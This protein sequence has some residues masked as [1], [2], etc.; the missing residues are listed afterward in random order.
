MPKSNSMLNRILWVVLVG[1]QIIGYLYILFFPEGWLEMKYIFPKWLPNPSQIALTIPALA[2]GIGVYFILRTK[3]IRKKITN[4]RIDSIIVIGLIIVFGYAIP[5]M[6]YFA[7]PFL[8]IE[9][10]FLIY[11]TI[12]YYFLIFH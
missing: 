4:L 3:Q 2:L 9:G 12:R 1:A 5:H 11:V 10:I 6:G 7:F 8:Y